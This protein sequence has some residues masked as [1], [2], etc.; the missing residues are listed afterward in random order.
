MT[1]D[2]YGKHTWHIDHIIPI[3]SFDLNDPNQVAIAFH[4]T[5]LQPMWAK[6]NIS[7]G[8]KITHPQMSLL[9]DEC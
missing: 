4:Y 9:L 1:L 2:N 3:S 7:K 5:N 8:A 6:E